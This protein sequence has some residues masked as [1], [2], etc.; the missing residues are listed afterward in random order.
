MKT[1]TK[2]SMCFFNIGGV[3][4]WDRGPNGQDVLCYAAGCRDFEPQLTEADYKR[5]N[6]LNEALPYSNR[7]D[8]TAYFNDCEV[9]CE[10]HSGRDKL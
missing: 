2:V 8:L 3:C 6:C 1:F 7:L 5:G 9:I 4:V 10:V